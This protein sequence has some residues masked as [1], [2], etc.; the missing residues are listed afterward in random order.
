MR[1]QVW[2]KKNI[3]LQKKNC[4]HEIMTLVTLG[5]MST[6]VSDDDDDDDDAFNVV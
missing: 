3:W 6:G 4:F 1:L 5:S 2:T